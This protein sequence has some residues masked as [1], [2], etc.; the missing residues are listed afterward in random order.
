MRIEYKSLLTTRPVLR[1][2]Y[3]IIR[4]YLG[5]VRLK[6]ENEEPWMR[7]VEGGGRVLLCT[8]HQQFFSAIRHFRTYR[9]WHPALMISKSRDGQMIAGV[10]ERTGWNAVRG[11]SSRDGKAALAEMTRCLQKNGLAAHIL[12]G[13]RGPAGRVKA[14]AIRLTL[15]SDAVIAPFHVEAENAWYFNSWD[16]FMVPKPFSRVTL[17]YGDCIRFQHTETDEQFEENRLMLENAMLPFLR[18]ASA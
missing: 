6:V 7:I 10:A 18:H 14:G 1:I 16:R 17:R 13:P 3:W 11:S 2:I 9:K 15:D 12:D 8:W 5:T 4:L